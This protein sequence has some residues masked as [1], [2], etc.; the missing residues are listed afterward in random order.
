MCQILNL[1][2]QVYST[3]ISNQHIHSFV[4]STPHVEFE[5]GLKMPANSMSV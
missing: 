1:K 3:H 2:V 5:V 4:E